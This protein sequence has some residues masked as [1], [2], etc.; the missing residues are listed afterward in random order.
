MT[1]VNYKYLMASKVPFRGLRGAFLIL[2]LLVLLPCLSQED[3]PVKL[4]YSSTMFG[5]GK[6]NV[7]DS[8]LSPL[9]YSGKSYSIMEESMKMTG[10]FNGNVV[11]QQLF[12]LDFSSTK[13]IFGN[14]TEYA[15]F[16]EYSYGLYYRLALLPKLKVFAGNQITGLTGFIYNMRNSNNPATGKA[17]INLTL[18][19]AAS[20]GF[21][22]KSWPFRLR[23]QIS[24]PFVGIMFSPH[25]GQSYY[26]ISLG[27]DNHLLHF[28]SYHNQVILRNNFSLEVPFNFM[29]LRLMYAGSIYETRINDID[30]RI[31]NNSFMIGF[32]KEFFT[33][34]GKKQVNGNYKRVFE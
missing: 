10:L 11:E 22:I 27:D 9:N 18:S 19:A 29:T 14:S 7:Y 6:V 23:Y 24:S 3:K 21:N 1:V 31:H 17:H 15:G 33:I 5:L 13:N 12:H 26:E 20:Y 28:S 25:Y 34:S 32:S 4:S 30:T 8:Y 2:L 16:L